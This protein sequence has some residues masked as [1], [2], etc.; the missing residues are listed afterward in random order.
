MNVVGVKIVH[1]EEVNSC[2]KYGAGG[3]GIV[4]ES[5][6]VYVDTHFCRLLRGRMCG[7]FSCNVWV[8]VCGP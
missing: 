7:W 4:G 1:D 2:V 3:V 6:R 8:G 5:R